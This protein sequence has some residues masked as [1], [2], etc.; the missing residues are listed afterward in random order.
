MTIVY[1]ILGL[2]AV[3][4]AVDAM[5][6]R[7]IRNLRESGVYPPPGQGVRGDVDRL[8]AL[9]RK[10]DAIKVYREIHGTDL[11]TAK[12]A[13]DKIAERSEFRAR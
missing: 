3:A 4:F 11:K 8:L 10:L 5:N 12:D 6:R 9:G 13:V 1:V 7:R 2:I